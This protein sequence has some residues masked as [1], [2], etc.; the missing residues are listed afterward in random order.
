M[1]LI[2][3]IS[4]FSP[5]NFLGHRFVSKWIVLSIDLLLISFSLILSFL[6][7]TNPQLQQISFIEYYKG[8]ISVLAFTLV[9]HFVFKPHLGLIR[10]T[11]LHDIKRVF[12]S[13]TLSFVLNII[14]ISY[15][16]NKINIHDYAIPLRVSMVNYFLSLYFLIQFRLG[17]KYIF[18]LGKR[19]KN[20]SKVVIYGAGATGHLV[21]DTL[22]TNYDVIA[23]IDDNSTIRGK[24]YKGIP[25][26][27]FDDK[28]EEFIKKNEI[29][30]VILSIQ[31]IAPN[32][33]RKIVDRCIDCDVEV[34]VVPPAEKWINGELKSSQLKIVKIDELLGRDVINLENKLLQYKLNEKTVLV[35]GAAGSIG[36]EIVRQLIHYNPKLVIL[37]DQAETPLYHLE[38]EINNNNKNQIETKVILAD[39]RDYNSM[40]SIFEKYQINWVFHAAAY[41][42]VPTMEMNPKE[43]VKINILGTKT[44]ADL[45]HM[46]KV[47]KMVFISTD[48]AVNPTNVMGATKRA[49]E[50]YVQSKNN[51]SSTSYIT[52]RFGN[53]LGSNGSVIPIFEKQIATGGPVKVTHPEITRYF[54][55]IPEAC[56]LVL[57]AGAMGEGGEIFVFDMGDSVKIIDLAE[58]MIRL[59]GLIPGKDIEIQFTGL[60]PGEKL[61]EELLNDKESIITTHHDK[62]M[63]AKVIQNNHHYVED[64][65]VNFKQLITLNSSD[66]MIVTELKKL[67]PEYISQNSFFEKLD[68]QPTNS[69]IEKN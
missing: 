25:I 10:H 60:R 1:S 59:S 58:K 51:H 28:F 29:S 66:N 47:E 50:M 30:Q 31:N 20:K 40:K 35:T 46:Y 26:I 42:H 69:L 57:E 64:I 38:L 13:R 34:V 37:V 44:I 62:I 65:F 53:V 52:T 54:M 2:H 43:A 49:A 23:F 11:T 63:K 48:K 36:S 32:Q 7:L 16:S 14:F 18:N 6:L 22:Y 24:F 21:Y 55:T 41:K 5:F 4:K 33:K 19:Q 15:I 17:I 67:I 45:A 8:V 68:N 12:Y 27:M 3:S 61:Y 39:L 9:G 56:Q